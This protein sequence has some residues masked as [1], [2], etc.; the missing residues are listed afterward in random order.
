MFVLETTTESEIKLIGCMAYSV[1][2]AEVAYMYARSHTNTLWTAKQIR[3]IKGIMK[4]QLYV[5]AEQMPEN[6]GWVEFREQATTMP[7]Y[8]F[9]VGYSV[10][11]L[12]YEGESIPT[13]SRG[14]YFVDKWRAL[15]PLKKEDLWKLRIF[16]GGY[17]EIKIGP[18]YA[19]NE[20]FVRLEGDARAILAT[21]GS[22]IV[23]RGR[24][25]A[26]I[27]MNAE[28]ETHDKSLTEA[29]GAC[30]VKSHDDSFVTLH[31]D[32]EAECWDRSVVSAADNARVISHNITVNVALG[33]KSTASG[34]Y[35]PH[36]L[37]NCG[38]NV[39]R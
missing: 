3:A 2:T 16:D 18:C 26:I 4:R 30:K 38:G 23:C 9:A 32:C 33:G 28:S 39:F 35:T 6:G 14:T 34:D 25:A 37:W 24:S 13:K 21:L 22:K 27:A 11:P 29:W 1:I 19:L 20:A 7:V 12:E 15:D 8:S 36:T 5:A 10:F 17:H 31:N